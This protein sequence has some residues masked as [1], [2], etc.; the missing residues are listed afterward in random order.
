[1]KNFITNA[2]ETTLKKRLETLINHSQELKFLVGFFYF[3]GWQ[4]LIDSLQKN[5]D[6]RLKILVGLSVDKIISQSFNAQKLMLELPIDDSNDSNEDRFQHFLISLTN[7]INQPNRDNETFYKQVE[8]FIECLENGRLQLR[9]TEQPNHA[10]L[11]LFCL[12]QQGIELVNQNGCFITGS[13]NLTDAGL[14]NQQEFNVEIKDY[15]FETAEQYFD[16]LWENAFVISEDDEYKGKIIDFFNNKSICAN[17]TPYEA[18]ALVLKTYLDLQQA[19]EISPRI[20]QILDNNGFEKYQYQLDA[21]RQA[22]GIINNYNGVI[23][24]DVVGLGKSVI[25]SMIAK[26]YDKR[27]LLICPPALMGDSHNKDSGWYEYLQKFELF[28]WDIISVGKIDELAENRDLLDSYD[29]VI[30]DEAHRFRNQ[31]SQAYASLANICRNKKVVLLTATPF[32]NSPA[33]IFALLKL[34]VVPKSSDMTL[35]GDL[36]K[37]FSHF[38]SEF[39]KLSNLLRDLASQ[40]SDKAN[41]AVIQ[42]ITRFSQSRQ[43]QSQ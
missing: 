28:N 20:E 10:K 18:Y 41:K 4:S 30:V 25:A 42:F 17:I 40:D 32:N 43:R 16:E 38:N 12:Q 31:D 5:P 26:H 2:Q 19:K 23:I 22:V 15:G 36:D 9:K 7:G 33:D 13:S 11:Y 8:F 21:V 39:K 24:A 34:F 29:M 3:S 6:S 37:L 1:M 14:A 35:D 27:G